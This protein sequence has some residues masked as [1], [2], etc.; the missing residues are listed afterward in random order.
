MHND[1]S[2]ECASCGSGK[3]VAPLSPPPYVKAYIIRWKRSCSC[4]A[5]GWLEY[6]EMAALFMPA[7]W[8]ST[9]QRLLAC[10]Q[11]QELEIEIEIERGKQQLLHWQSVGARDEAVAM[12]GGRMYL[13]DGQAECQATTMK[14]KGARHVTGLAPR[15]LLNNLL[16]SKQGHF[17][18]RNMQKKLYLKLAK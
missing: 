16:S 4:Y 11:E 1:K 14:I 18:C 10:C 5:S 7:K 8:R 3:N 12:T 2:L 17:N 15:S 6:S 13:L 9:G